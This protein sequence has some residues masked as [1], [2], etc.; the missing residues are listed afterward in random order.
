[1]DHQPA[2]EVHAYLPNGGEA[3]ET[4]AEDWKIPDRE[5]QDPPG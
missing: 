2:K 1:M 4:L 5:A 3:F